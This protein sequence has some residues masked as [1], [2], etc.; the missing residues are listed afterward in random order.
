MRYSAVIFY[1]LSL[2]LAL[3]ACWE[4][5]GLTMHAI[6]NQEWL[7]NWFNYFN[8]MNCHTKQI[9]YE[10]Y[11]EYTMKSWSTTNTSKK[12]NCNKCREVEGKVERRFQPTFYHFY[13]YYQKWF[14]FWLWMYD[15]KMESFLLEFIL[16]HKKNITFQGNNCRTIISSKCQID[17]RQVHL[18]T[19]D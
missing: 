3:K 19:P 1:T 11:Y 10:Y 12:N 7:L 2:L 6:I 9:M 5:N 14:F 13:H 8:F 18:H 16:A 17:I 15:R 4:T